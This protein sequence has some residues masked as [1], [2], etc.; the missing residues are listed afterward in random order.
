MSILA[1][2]IRLPEEVKS[3]ST[4]S[5]MKYLC[6]MYL[7]ETAGLNVPQDAI[8]KAIAEFGAYFN[9]L[10]QGGHLLGRNTLQ[11]TR[12][13]TTVRVRDGQTL[14]TDGPFAETKEQ[15]GGYFLIEARDLNEAIRVAAGFPGARWGCVEV[16]PINEMHQP[17]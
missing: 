8:D 5:R 3:K 14:M 12:T 10:Q 16:R 1:G 4:D 11:P 13:A 9:A 17:K 6:L 2:I 7:A 15:L